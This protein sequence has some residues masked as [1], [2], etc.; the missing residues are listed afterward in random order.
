M[1]NLNLVAGAMSTIL[2]SIAFCEGREKVGVILLL[3]SVA[4]LV[5]GGLEIKCK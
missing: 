5:I 1:M 3:L 4:N 2:R